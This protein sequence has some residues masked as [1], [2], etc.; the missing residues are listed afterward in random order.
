MNHHLFIYGTLLHTL[1]TRIGRYLKANGE[2]RGDAYATGR[3]YDLGQ[4]PGFW[5]DPGSTKRVYGQVYHL[6]NPEEAFRELDRYEGINPAHP[7]QNE[8][9]RE[10]IPAT[11]NGQ[12]VPCWCYVLNQPPGGLAE[13]CSGNYLDFI[14]GSGKHRDF[15]GTV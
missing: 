1:S 13:I 8:Y 2:L 10:E 5:Y 6:H 14:E 3:L 9:R 15:L 12:P 7:C 4:Y 11:L